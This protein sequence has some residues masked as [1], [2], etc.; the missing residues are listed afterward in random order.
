MNR[1]WYDYL[2]DDTQPNL[3]ASCIIV[4]SPPYLAMRIWYVVY[5]SRR[6][7]FQSF[8]NEENPAISDYEQCGWNETDVLLKTLNLI[9][10]AISEITKVEFGLIFQNWWF[11]DWEALKSRQNSI[12]D[13][14]EISLD[15][16]SYI[17]AVLN[18]AE[19]AKQHA[20]FSCHGI[21]E[22][23]CEWD[24]QGKTSTYLPQNVTGWIK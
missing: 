17:L 21:A 22:V 8:K 19:S 6:S 2:K 9:F 23:I 3:L 5:L 12:L 1:Y 14:D 7:T 15:L 10:F 16:L 13:I 11:I 20:K 24:V 18:S 4:K